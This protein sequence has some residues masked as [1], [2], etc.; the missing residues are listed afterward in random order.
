MEKSSAREHPG[1]DLSA[2]VEMTE[3]SRETQGRDLSAS[4][5][6]TVVGRDDRG[7]SGRR[8]DALPVVE[9][10]RFDLYPCYC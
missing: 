10:S 4:V 5:E 3:V 6:M 1:K 8:R 9:S 2:S 7:K